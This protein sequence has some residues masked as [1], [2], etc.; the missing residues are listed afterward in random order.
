MSREH[1]RYVWPA[2]A[3]RAAGGS[4]LAE[5]PGSLEQSGAERGLP[6]GQLVG[7]RR[8]H[9]VFYTGAA[10]RGCP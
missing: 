1:G 5:A 8:S 2:S 9:L 3:A 4:R 10:G 6:E 7:R